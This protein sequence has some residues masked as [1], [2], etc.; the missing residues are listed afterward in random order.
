MARK[1]TSVRTQGSDG[2]KSA[3]A[4]EIRDLV[5]SLGG[6]EILKG[7]DLSIQPGS[8][9]SLLGPSGSGKSTLLKTLAGLIDP[10]SGALFRGGED[11]SSLPP[12]KRGMV[13]VFQDLRLFPHMSVADNV[14]FGLRMRG[15]PKAEREAAVR[16]SLAQVQLEGMEARRPA[17]L[18]GGQQQRVALARA[19]AVGPDLLLLDEPFSS[20]DEA[21]RQQMREL[22][23]D[24][25]KGLGLT[26]LLVTHDQ[27]EALMLS[28]EIAVIFD[29]RLVQVAS[30]HECYE[31]PATPQVADYF[32]E[33]NYLPGSLRAGHFTNEALGIKLDLSTL[34]PELLP[35][36]LQE[37]EELLLMLRPDCVELG[38]A[39]EGGGGVAG[40]EGGADAA[41]TAGEGAAGAEATTGAEAAAGEGA[42]RVA[43][44]ERPAGEAAAG[45][46]WFIEAHSYR[47]ATS[48][49]RLRWAGAGGERSNAAHLK[50][51]TAAEVIPTTPRF[52]PSAVSALNSERGLLVT[53]AEDYPVVL[54]ARVSV[55][56]DL[57]RAVLYRP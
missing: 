52:S 2:L 38:P 23:R 49:L 27:A 3:P 22:V 13:I 30:P 15:L 8:F 47:G 33:V 31:A 9:T 11:I 35:S 1:S 6:N 57:S 16:N 54:K 34:R 24:L 28:D 18:S 14:G 7:I 55:S 45:A 26:T 12:E 50:S 4:Y 17:E 36:K 53:V 21:L 10:S 56:F 41:A 43:G 20:L 48:Q 44:A 39:G 37:G 29:G 5:V 40:A 19:L 25:H 51:K 32:G 42:A 46:A